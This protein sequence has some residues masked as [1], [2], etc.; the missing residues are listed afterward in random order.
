MIK[1]DFFIIGAPK[2][3]TTSLYEYLKT[4]PHICFSKSKEP[5][6]FS[7]EFEGYRTTF[8]TEEYHRKEFHQ[9]EN[10]SGIIG[11]SSV[12]YLY[13]NVA[14]REI[15]RYNPDARLIILLRNPVDMLHSLHSQMLFNQD[16][17]IGDFEEAWLRQGS[18]AT[19]DNIPAACRVAEF[20]QYRKIGTYGD[21]LERVFRYFPHEQV[22]VVLFDDL[23]E[24]PARIY[25]E[26]L[27]FLG[28][29][30]DNRTDFR[31]ENRNKSIMF[32]PAARLLQKPPAAAVSLAKI[33]QK[34]T[35]TQRLG[36]HSLLQ[37]LN[38]RFNS[39]LM[40]RPPLRSEFRKELAEAFSSD[41]E[42]VE[43]LIGTDLSEWKQPKHDR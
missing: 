9:C 26:T 5:N 39:R 12:W 10:F 19:G 29:E 22:K 34:L 27:E 31:V 4:H 17:D 2:C 30:P 20:L 28:L 32:E 25:F 36:I 16:E 21:Q 40:Q 18:R 42:K 24:D 37:K 8:S 3:G 13:S 11:E 15:H 7:H 6:H 1:V 33:L 23:K 43:C 35:G 14:V 38:T 41:I